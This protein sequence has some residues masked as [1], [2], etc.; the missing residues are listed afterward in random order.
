M[1]LFY[2]YA[3]LVLLLLVVTAAALVALACLRPPQETR[4]PIQ[5]RA[6]LPR[7]SRLGGVRRAHSRRRAA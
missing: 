7:P 2:L 1:L 3:G 6:A 5:S 4:F